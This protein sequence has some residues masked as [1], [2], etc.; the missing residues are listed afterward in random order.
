M[1]NR[2]VIFWIGVTLILSIS[3]FLLWWYFFI[4]AQTKTV[5]SEAAARG[6]SVN[7]PVFESSGGSMRGNITEL[8]ESAQSA[9]GVAPGK[10]ATTTS[11]KRARLFRASAIP[12]VGLFSPSTPKSS[13]GEILFV[14]RPSGNI[15]TLTLSGGDARRVTNTLIPQVYEVIWIDADS[16]VVR[17]SNDGGITLL[18]FLGT[19]QTASSSVATLVGSYLDDNVV[20]ISA[21]PGGK[22]PSLFYLVKNVGEVVGILAESDGKNPK[23]VWSSPISGWNIFWV[24]EDRIVLSQKAAEGVI[25]SAYLLSPKSGELSLVVGNKNGL[26]AVPHPIK[27]AVI[28]STSQNG[29]LKLYGR[30]DG[31]EKELPI[32]TMADKCVWGAGLRAFC[33]VPLSFSAFPRAALPDAW[34]RGEVA[35]S[36]QWFSID[37]VEGIATSLLDPVDDFRGGLGANTDSSFDVVNPSIDAVGKHLLFI[38][39]K[40]ST[41]W[42]LSI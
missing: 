30:V 4:S 29:V 25:G 23:R 24:S 20:A 40:T 27:N 6:F 38:D 10:K 12:S 22:E 36:D 39:K 26:V 35:F 11:A 31:L 3:T 33:A 42:V 37:V 19:V 28:Y 8:F 18:T 14:E 41:P 21:R 13:D 9:L 34:Y 5:E 32:V 16:L 7:A 17:H 1:I 2:R 15:F